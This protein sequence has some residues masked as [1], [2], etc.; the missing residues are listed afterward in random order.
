[1]GNRGQVFNLIIFQLKRGGSDEDE[2]VWGGSLCLA[3][4]EI[5]DLNNALS[6]SWN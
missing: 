1:M 5:L 2:A 4:M 3:S 6:F